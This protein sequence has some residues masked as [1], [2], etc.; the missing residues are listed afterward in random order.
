MKR[1]VSAGYEVIV[2]APYDDSS[3]DIKKLGVKYIELKMD[4][5]GSNP[6]NDLKLIYK[7]YRYFKELD[8]FLIFNYTIKPN[9]YAT[10]AAKF[11]NVKSIAVI[12]GLGYTFINDNFIS[13]IAKKL[14]KFS[15]KYADGVWFINQ[16]DRNK[17]V[18]DH[19]VKRKLIKILP[20]EGVDMYKYKPRP[21]RPKDGKFRFVL[22]ARLLWD[23][24]VGELVEATKILKK[25]NKS[26]EVQLIGF[27][28]CDNPK[29]I[30][31]DI[32]QSWEDKGIVSY[33]GSTDDVRDFIG[34]ADCV[35][36][37]SYREGISKIL[38]ESASMAKPIIASNVPGCRDIVEHTVSGFL[39]KVK[40]PIDLA[41]KMKK[42]L[43]M[44]RQE[45][46][47]MGMKGREFVH[48]E[49]DEE[50]VIDIYIDTI[51][52]YSETINNKRFTLKS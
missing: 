40:D 32:V 43:N 23:K 47:N 4:N 49:Y 6:F 8:P 24:G 35:V 14:Y 18:K 44:S 34:N 19:L 31:R 20:S 39:C 48:R 10:L 42:V 28:D 29:S 25:S 50:I 16:D 1:L 15:L 36:L 9:I 46:L 13:K 17:F 26:I 5:K 21:N 51:K 22:I 33:M 37:P 7:L 11:A 38:L 12:T 41:I 52:S 30:S 2:L 27:V 45:L 3:E